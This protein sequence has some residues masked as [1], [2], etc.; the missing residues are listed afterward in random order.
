[1]SKAA[2]PPRPRTDTEQ[3]QTM[4]KIVR[5]SLIILASI[6]VGGLALHFAIRAI[7]ALHT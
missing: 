1:M 3:E 4:P 6:A 5:K 2:A 7:V